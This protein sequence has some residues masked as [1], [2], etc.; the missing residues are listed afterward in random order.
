MHMPYTTNPKMPLVRMEAVRLVK[1]RDWSAR[2]AACHLGYAQGTIVQWYKKDPTGGWQRIP[3]NHH[4]LI[5]TQRNYHR[6]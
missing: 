2:K 6:K 3:H 1:Y 5:I 4:G